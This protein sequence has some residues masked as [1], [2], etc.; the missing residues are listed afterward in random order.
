MLFQTGLHYLQRVESRYSWWRFPDDLR[1]P[2]VGWRDGE[3][4]TIL[5]D[6]HWRDWDSNSGELV[7]ANLQHTNPP[8]PGMTSVAQQEHQI[9]ALVT[10]ADAVKRLIRS[11]TEGNARIC[12]VPTLSEGAD[13]TFTIRLAIRCETA[14]V[15]GADEF[16]LLWERI[17]GRA[18]GTLLETIGVS[19]ETEIRGVA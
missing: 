16:R 2:R 1:I 11:M 10:H 17:I 19:I 9:R 5:L 3:L 8:S 6:N 15:E 13:N 14:D 4:Q 18:A 12:I 7:V